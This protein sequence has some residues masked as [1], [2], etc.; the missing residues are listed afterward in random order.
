MSVTTYGPYIFGAPE[1]VPFELPVPWLWNAD[2]QDWLTA[3]GP[4]P[5]TYLATKDE[6]HLVEMNEA[7]QWQLQ[8]AEPK[9]FRP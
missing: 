9:N 3:I 2:P 4:G 7:G 5:K 8:E 1:K 6:L